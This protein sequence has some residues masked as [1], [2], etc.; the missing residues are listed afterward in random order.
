MHVRLAERKWDWFCDHHPTPD[1]QVRA[2]NSPGNGWKAICRNRGY[3]G[4]FSFP[5][6]EGCSSASHPRNGELGEPLLEMGMPM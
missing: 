3:F 4:Y 5:F 2:R 1:I 6:M